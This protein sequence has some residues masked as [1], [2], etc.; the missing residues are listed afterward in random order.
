VRATNKKTKYLLEFTGERVV[1]EVVEPALWNE[2]I[3]RYLYAASLATGK[4]VLDA[5]CGTGYGTACLGR[6][7][8]LAVG[9]DVSEDAIAFAKSH[10]GKRAR[11][12]TGSAE[13][14]SEEDGSFDVVTAFEVIEHLE[15]WPN[16]IKEA[17]RVLTGDGVFLV[18]TPNKTY[19]AETRGGSGPNPYHVHEFDYDDFL[20]A[21]TAVFPHV[22]ILGQ[23]RTESFTFRAEEAPGSSWVDFGEVTEPV[24]RA[25]FYLAVC[26]KLEFQAP[27]F[28]FV[29]GAGNLLWER[30]RHI[31]LLEQQI[32]EVNR[33]RAALLVKHRQIE[34]SVRERTDWAQQLD[35]ELRDAMRQRD[36]ALDQLHEVEKELDTRTAWVCRLESD[37]RD[38]K[39]QRDKALAVIEQQQ[40]T[41]EARTAWA[42]RS[43]E[44]LARLGEERKRIVALLDERQKVI[45]ERSAWA[46]RV[47]EEVA[48][49]R[50]DFQ[51]LVGMLEERE[52]TIIERT[53]WAHGLEAELQTR[54]DWARGLEAELQTRTDWAR[55]LDTELQMLRSEFQ[56]LVAKLDERDRTIAE[57]TDWARG[58]D[59]ELQTLR[60]EFQN[61]EGKLYEHERTIAERTD[62][63]SGLEAELQTLRSEFQ[64]LVGILE[65]RDHTITERTNW[66]NGLEAEMASLRNNLK[67]LVGILDAAKESRWLKLGNSLGLGPKLSATGR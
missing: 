41:I 24:A 33:D 47:D 29:P 20:A 36:G 26:S 34:E 38:V 14:F 39:E 2:H 43:D 66:A 22:A 11:F 56:S 13:Q 46:M 54:T 61:L 18:S 51:N 63:A 4:R 49:L 64:N 31:T 8:A 7:A 57:R 52:R 44:E 17:N 67:S 50:S 25:H 27:A 30:E 21:L 23:N 1:P 55:G 58:L 59:A 42:K 65:E 32:E 15:N 40:A 60:S 37:A 10:Y 35:G 48:K 28:V 53:D 9:F 3:S 19:Y 62:W 5:G 12:R 6:G 16:L 45:E